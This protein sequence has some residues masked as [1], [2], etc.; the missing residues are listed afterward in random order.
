M[1]NSGAQELG[2][3]MVL[4]LGDGKHGKENSETTDTNPPW[5][6]SQKLPRDLDEYEYSVG[7]IEGLQG[8]LV[9]I[10]G[11]PSNNRP[12]WTITV[13]GRGNKLSKLL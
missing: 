1:I 7:I 11:L 10:C 3:D 5:T 12:E 8:L 13:L 2:I 6:A 9:F 4:W